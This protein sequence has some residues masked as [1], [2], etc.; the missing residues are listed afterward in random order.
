MRLLFDQN[1]SHRLLGAIDDLFPGS[2][3]IRLLGLAEADDL[4]IWNHAKQHNLL[5]SSPKAPIIRTGTNSVE[6]LQRL[7]GSDV[8]MHPSI[9]CT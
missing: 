8:A 7:S 4:T 1:L 2:L 5:S 6:R 9:K 3:H